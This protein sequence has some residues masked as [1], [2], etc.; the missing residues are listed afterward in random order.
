VTDGFPL[1]L[2]C[3]KGQR[4]RF[5][6]QNERF[7]DRMRSMAKDLVK[8]KKPLEVILLV[9]KAGA[10]QKTEARFSAVEERCRQLCSES[11]VRDPGQPKTFKDVAELWMNG[12]LCRRYP[13]DV[14][15][16]QGTH[17]SRVRS[18]CAEIF[19]KLGHVPVAAVTK[20]LAL[21]VKA[22]VSPGRGQGSRRH[23][24][25]VIRRVMAMAVDPLGLIE[26]SPIPKKFVPP[27]GKP[28]MFAF[29]YPE[30]DQALLADERIPFEYRLL[31]GLIVRTGLRFMEALALEPRDIDLKKG[32]LTVRKSKTGVP[33]LFRCSPD[34]VASLAAWLETP[35]ERLFAE[36]SPSN[37]ARLFRQHLKAAL[38]QAGL[39]LRDLFTR[40]KEQRPIRIHDLRATFVTLYLGAG[41][42]ERWVM[43][44]TGHQQSAM[45]AKY[46]RQAR[47]AA[48][49]ELGP[50]LP[51]DECLRAV[52]GADGVPLLDP[53]PSRTA[54]ADA[55]IGQP[56]NS[57]PGNA[58]VAPLGG[59]YGA[60]SS[61]GRRM[62]TGTTPGTSHGSVDRSAKVSAQ[63]GAARVA[64]R[65]A[66]APRKPRQKPGLS[67]TSC[68]RRALQ[69]SAPAKKSREKRTA[70]PGTVPGEPPQMG[71]VAQNLTSATSSPREE[72][73]MSEDVETVLARALD[74][75]SKAGQWETVTALAAELTERRRAKAGVVSLD[76]ARQRK[77]DR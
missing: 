13:D 16:L 75:A 28:P 35:R 71:G 32:T 67:S 61:G 59:G 25:L 9:L 47:H 60:S 77:A 69:A 72:N 34:V 31:Y 18:I 4:P 73:D 50:P 14:K 36:V 20:E 2:R 74:R 52:R 44:R 10:A 53:S 6:L 49:L 62:R 27:Q 15:C 33:R 42:T 5:C 57:T 51:L 66:R 41:Q 76:A 39:S 46:S 40:T 58:E 22:D 26:H 38:E 65:V 56:G 21:E 48:E 8:A 45:L 63:P 55:A 29:L 23:F 30:E 7:A 24:A 37:A 11:N 3:G 19:P 54:E 1:Q 70:D 68:T 17:L 64:Q 43:D 12:T